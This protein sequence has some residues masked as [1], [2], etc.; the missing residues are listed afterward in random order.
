MWKIKDQYL[1]QIVKGTRVELVGLDLKAAGNVQHFPMLGNLTAMGQAARSET[2][3]N[4]KK[5]SSLNSLYQRN[6]SL[7]DYCK[8]RTFAGSPGWKILGSGNLLFSW[9]LQ[10]LFL[11][12]HQ[13]QAGTCLLFI[14]FYRSRSR[15]SSHGPNSL[16]LDLVLSGLE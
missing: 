6:T 12:L 16:H 14:T 11:S 8:N 10:G 2:C 13:T 1:I 5:W 15:R 3:E 4:S 7:C 9:F